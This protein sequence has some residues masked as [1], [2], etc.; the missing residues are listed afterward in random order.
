MVLWNPSTFTA[1]LCKGHE[2]SAM[3]LVSSESKENDERHFYSDRSEYTAAG[4]WRKHTL[5]MPNVNQY[6]C[7]SSRLN[8]YHTETRPQKG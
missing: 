6:G 3:P 5:A 2:Q 1:A 7:N 4:S 8:V